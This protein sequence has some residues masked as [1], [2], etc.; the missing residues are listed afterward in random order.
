MNAPAVHPS[1]ECPS[2]VVQPD[3]GPAFEPVSG[4]AGPDDGQES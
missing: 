3:L 1:R 4:A 2:G